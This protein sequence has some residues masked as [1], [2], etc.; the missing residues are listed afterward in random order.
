[1]IQSGR[2]E[3]N[4]SELDELRRYVNNS[5]GTDPEM[6]TDVLVSIPKKGDIYLLCSD[7]LSKMVPDK[8]GENSIERILL[9]Q[10]GDIEKVCQRLVEE[11]NQRGGRDNIT[12]VAI[13]ITHVDSSVLKDLEDEIIEFPQEEKT[14]Q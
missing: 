12:V 11:A 13:E 1:M 14:F 10:K 4:E 3:G 7:G 5:L 9:S 2:V 8:D 6:E